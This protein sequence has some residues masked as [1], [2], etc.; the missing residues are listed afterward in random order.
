MISREQA[1]IGGGLAVLLGIIVAVQPGVV[2]PFE[3]GEAVL[4]IVGLVAVYL[5]Y[6]AYKKRRW[7]TFERPSLPEV[8]S[9]YAFETPGS[10]FTDRLHAAAATKRA[11]GRETLR[12]ELHQ[13]TIEVLMVYRGYTESDADAAI[14]DGSWTDD[15]YAAAFF[16]FETPPRPLSARIEDALEGHIAFERRGKHV[17]AEL[18]NITEER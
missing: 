9:K 12:K 13:T 4:N 6:R 7:A 2:R 3:V 16:T 5:A 1:F 11:D 14:E 15:P 8:E 18:A 10:S 17:I